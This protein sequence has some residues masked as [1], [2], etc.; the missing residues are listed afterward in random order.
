MNAALVSAAGRLTARIAALSRALGRE[1]TLDPAACL[2]RSDTIQLGRPGRTSPN[3]TCRLL[4]AA[5]DWVALNLPRDSDW[6]LVPALFGQQI[7]T[8]GWEKVEALVR[9]MLSDGLCRQAADLGMAASRVGETVSDTPYPAF[10]L[11]GSLRRRTRLRV[12]DL[13]SLWAGPLCGGVLAALGADVIKVETTARPDPTRNLPALNARLNGGKTLI[14]TD[15]GDADRRADI[16]DLICRAD[17]LVTSARPRALDQLGWSEARLRSANPGLIH[18]AITVHGFYGAA[19][20]RVGFGDDAAAAGGLVDL[21]ADG[22]PA[23]LGDALADPLTGLAAASGALAALCAGQGGLIDA[24]L[25]RTAAGIR[26]W[27]REGL[28]PKEAAA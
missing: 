17:I 7:D 6:E 15:F 22:T 2:D 24:A 13:S 5:D 8:P 9:G 26:A 19:G 20:L 10:S 1:V 12:V 16:F 11:R 25:A 21:A 28:A 14:Q 3:G 27:T 23:F 4:R 18:V